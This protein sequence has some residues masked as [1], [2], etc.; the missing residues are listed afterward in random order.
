MITK[1]I[2]IF[3]LVFL[4]AISIS[5]S[6]QANSSNYKLSTGIVSS[7]GGTVNS[8]NYKN[9]V[10]TG[11]IGGIVNSSTYKNLLGFFYTWLLGDDQP[12]T[13]DDQ[14]EG[15]FCCSNLCSSSACPVEGGGEAAAAGGGGGGA[16]AGGGGGGLIL[17][18][19]FSVSPSS[20]KVKLT[21]GESTEETLTIRNKGNTALTVSLDVE[22]VKQYLSLPDDSIDLQADESAVVTLNFIGKQVGSFPGEIIAT[23]DGIEKSIPI[24]IEVISELVLFDVKLDIPSAYAEVKQGD[25]LKTQITLLNVGAPEKVD[26]FASY[27]I[28]DLRGNI[29]YEETETFAVEKQVSYPKLLRTHESTIPGS[30]V[31]IVEIRYADSFAVSSQLFRVVEK[32]ELV[33]IRITKSTGTM[34]VLVFILV[35]FVFLLIYKLFPFRKKHRKKK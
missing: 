2:F 14:C 35:G 6:F 3:S 19:D 9:Y 22:G 25:E 1:K 17:Q 33:D 10:V 15:G 30:Y 32:K 13:S 29:I 26:V 21:L 7:G 12:C 18:K 20:I 23:A 11:I 24:V 27:F 16:A 28:K 34:L 5:Y 4:I 31:A 8:S